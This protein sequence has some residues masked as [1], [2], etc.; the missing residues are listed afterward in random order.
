MLFFP[1]AWVMPG[2]G[3]EIGESLETSLMREI[4]EEVGINLT[5]V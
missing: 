3:V 1:K 2:G 5:R 4:G